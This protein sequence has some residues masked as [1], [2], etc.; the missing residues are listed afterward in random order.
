ML[1]YRPLTNRTASRGGRRWREWSIAHP[2]KTENHLRV[3]A[4]RP[5]KCS[6]PRKWYAKVTW[7]WLMWLMLSIRWG[8]QGEELDFNQRSAEIHTLL[9][10]HAKQPTHLDNSIPLGVASPDGGMG[11]LPKCLWRSISLESNQSLKNN[12]CQIQVHRGVFLV[13]V[14][15]FEEKTSFMTY[16]YSR[17]YQPYICA[18]STNLA[19]HFS[20]AKRFFPRTSGRGSNLDAELGAAP[21]AALGVVSTNVGDRWRVRR[22]QS[23]TSRA[24]IWPR[25]SCITAYNSQ[26]SWRWALIRLFS[27]MNPSR[28]HLS[29]Q[30]EPIHPQIV[31]WCLHTICSRALRILLHSTRAK[32]CR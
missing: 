13:Y 21:V 8:R 29:I 3:A 1:I 24:W 6:H 14:R 17:K 5:W 16:I 10:W 19:G 2:H 23:R 26:S 25:N 27:K 32:N 11:W 15:L 18:L 31:H 28:H 7:I 12:S 20:Y 4:V 30:F 9:L 22:I